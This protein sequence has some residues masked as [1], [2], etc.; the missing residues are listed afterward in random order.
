MDE[1]GKKK[2]KKNCAVKQRLELRQIYINVL[3]L[4]CLL[5]EFLEKPDIEMQQVANNM[6]WTHPDGA[7]MVKIIMF[8]LFSDAKIE[9]EIIYKFKKTEQFTDKQRKQELNKFVA[10]R[11]RVQNENEFILNLNSVKQIDTTKSKQ[12]EKLFDVKFMLK[13]SEPENIKPDF[14]LH[15]YHKHKSW[16]QMQK[17]TKEKKKRLV[18]KYFQLH[19]S[20]TF[21]CIFSGF[22]N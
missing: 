1:F 11:Q 4:K 10:D 12:I 7:F 3:R 5:V 20:H 9:N 18:E 22:L 8:L 21:L 19:F 17:Y 6:H 2:K 15:K 14:K 16:K 13:I